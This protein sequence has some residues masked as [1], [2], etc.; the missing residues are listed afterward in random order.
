[1]VVLKSTRSASRVD[2]ASG[3]FLDRKMDRK[4]TLYR[5]TQ[6]ILLRIFFFST[7]LALIHNNS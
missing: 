5:L 3:L 6:A 1:M 4:P 2:R 7:T